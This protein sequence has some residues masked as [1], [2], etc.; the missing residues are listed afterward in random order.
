[1]A[2]PIE[3]TP[4]LKGEEAIKLVRSVINAR[5]DPK[6]RLEAEK[7]AAFVKTLKRR[8]TLFHGR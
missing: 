2:H 3:A 1:M 8:G 7:R 4:V 5:P 6:K